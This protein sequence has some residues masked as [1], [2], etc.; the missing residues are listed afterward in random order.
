MAAAGGNRIAVPVLAAA[1]AAGL[2]A[3]VSYSYV[4]AAGTQHVVGWV[5]L[6]L[7]PPAPG[8]A[9]ALSITTLG[10]SAYAR[11]ATGAGIALG[12]NKETLLAVPDN[13]C[14]DMR[15]FGVCGARAHETTGLP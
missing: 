12:Y 8:G 10:L 11:P 13:A 6:D 14:I 5:K 3:C 4:D 2:C 9:G 15:T 7:P 1:A